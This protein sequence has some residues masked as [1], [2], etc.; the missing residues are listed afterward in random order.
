M[1]QSQASAAVARPAATTIEKRRRTWDDYEG[2][3]LG[4][5]AV[6]VFL[7]IVAAM[8]ALDPD[9]RVALYVAP[10]WFALLAVSYYAGRRR[11]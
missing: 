2:T 11:S 5:V 8:F 10:F 4:V 9:T 3:V 6:I 1:A 7:L